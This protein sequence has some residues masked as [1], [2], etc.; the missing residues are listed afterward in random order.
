MTFRV[1]VLGAADAGGLV[2]RVGELQ[3]PLGEARVTMAS[4][5]VQETSKQP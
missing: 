2:G 5:P 4:D 3:L 1:D